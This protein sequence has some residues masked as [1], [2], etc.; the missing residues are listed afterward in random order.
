MSKA[1]LRIGIVGAG[2]FASYQHI[3]ALRQIERVKL[4]AISRR[5]SDKLSQIQRAFE[6]PEAYTDWREMLNSARLDA[7]VIT[8]PDHLHAEH[9]IAA[10]ER[11]KHVLLEKPM[12]LRY[13]DAIAIAAA[14]KASGTVLMVGYNNR[15]AGKWR[16][17]KKLLAEGVLGTIRQ[18]NFAFAS[19]RRWMWEKDSL[20]ND[21]KDEMH[22][23]VKKMGLPPDMFDDWGHTW[24]KDPAKSGGGMF[25]NNATHFVDLALWLAGA[26]P[27]E[28]AAFTENAGLPVDCF[29]NVQS[30]LDNGVLLSFTS[31]DAVPQGIMGGDRRIMIVG[32][33]ALLYDSPD[34][35]LWIHR[36]EERTEIEPQFPAISVSQ[37]FVSSVLD[38]NPNLAPGSECTWAVALTEA[39]YRSAAE[40][41]IVSIKGSAIR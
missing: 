3:P 25:V 39:A 19:F 38:E 18:A 13:K 4:V 21:M 8:T 40:G 6:I 29:V 22:A 33:D 9:A 17:A 31:A 32:D 14:A 2:L 12:A 26:P 41:R 36:G 7:V 24:Y 10:L 34:G 37:A 11:G 27:S 20:P 28:V 16:T 5:D 15:V 23:V 35:S 1:E 30:R